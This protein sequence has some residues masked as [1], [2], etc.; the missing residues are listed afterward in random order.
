LVAAGL[1]WSNWRRAAGVARYRAAWVGIRAAGLLSGGLVHVIVGTWPGR[2]PKRELIASFVTIAIAMVSMIG[3]A[4]AVLRHRVLGFG[5]A[6]SRAMVWGLV[7]GAL[8]AIVGLMHLLVAPVLNLGD[9]QTSLGFTAAAAMLSALVL[10][11]GYRW[12]NALVSAC[13][14]RD[15][16][17]G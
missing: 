7:I 17:H 13:S 4:Y 15:S 10:P 1:L 12:A 8:A 14:R 9:P 2:N 16:R 6:F 5:F 3:L 11:K